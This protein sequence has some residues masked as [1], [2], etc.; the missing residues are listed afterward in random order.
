MGVPRSARDQYYSEP[1]AALCA[2]IGSEPRLWRHDRDLDERKI[3][4]FKAKEHILSARI[5]TADGKPFASFQR[6]ADSS[7]PAVPTQDPYLG[8]S[9]A[10]HV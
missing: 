2:R 1:K 3:Q 7:L 8:E 9:L 5:Y 4:A 6:M 10:H